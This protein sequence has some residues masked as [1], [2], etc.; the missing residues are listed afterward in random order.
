MALPTPRRIVIHVRRGERDVASSAPRVRSS[1]SGQTG[2]PAP[3]VTPRRLSR[4]EPAPHPRQATQF[5]PVQATAPLAFATHTLEPH[6]PAQLRP[7]RAGIA[8]AARDGSAWAEESDAR[9]V[10]L[11]LAFIRDAEGRGAYRNRGPIPSGLMKKLDGPPPP[12]ACAGADCATACP[13]RS[14]RSALSA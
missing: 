3:P 8:G 14:S 7:I 2:H 9:A 13:G 10:D 11:R 4:V 5:H 6:A 1:R 12:P